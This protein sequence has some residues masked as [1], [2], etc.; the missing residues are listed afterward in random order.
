M[1]WNDKLS[2]GVKAIDDDHKVLLGLANKLWDSITAE[3]GKQVLDDILDELV[4]YTTYHFER[5]EQLFAYT[6]YPDASEHKKQHDDL[7]KRVLEIQKRYREGA[8]ALTLEVMNFLK[9][10]LYDHILRSD[11]R[12]GPYLNSKGIK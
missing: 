9:D 12:F 8:P 5:E 11:V 7:T 4:K 6:S 1:V 2:V 3:R 10:W